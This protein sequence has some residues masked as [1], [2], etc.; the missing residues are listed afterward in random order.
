MSNIVQT[1]AEPTMSS[2]EIADLVDK[3]HRVVTRSMDTLSE[4]GLITFRQTVEKSTG[5]RPAT[6]YHVNQRDSYIVVAQ[7][8]PE[9]T[10]RLVDRWQ[11]LEKQVAQPP[12]LDLSNPASLRT[13]HRELCGHYDAQHAAHAA[14]AAGTTINIQVK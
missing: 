3:D 7:L 2:R 13:L 4:K 9:F 1:N 12:A 14:V 10:A 8:S 6:L 5:G 11:Q